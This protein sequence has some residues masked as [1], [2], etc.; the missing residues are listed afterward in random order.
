M[1]FFNSILSKLGMGTAEAAELPA[2]TAATGAAASAAAPGVA[3]A[4]VTPMSSVDVVGKLTAL[5]AAHAEPSNWQSS[6]VDLL[7]LLGMDSSITARKA[8]AVEMACPADKMAD[9]AH[10]NM[11]L[12]QAV[13]QKLAAN[14]GNIPKDLLH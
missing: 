12:H 13:L 8:M 7:K 4:V 3:A 2:A 14:G 1:S 6:I 10:M 5:A 11:W 9:S